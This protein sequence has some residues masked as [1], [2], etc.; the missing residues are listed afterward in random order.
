V[1]LGFI[2]NGIRVALMAIL[3]A[4]SN[5]SAFTYWHGGDGSLIFAIISM[6]LFGIFCWFAYVR[7]PDLTSDA[8]DS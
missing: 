7:N 1:L 4:S 8:G 5:K 2:V 6:V 3:V